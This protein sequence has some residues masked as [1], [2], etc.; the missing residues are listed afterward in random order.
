MGH[1]NLQVRPKPRMPPY[2]IVMNKSPPSTP[3][4]SSLL[5]FSYEHIYDELTYRN[6]YHNSQSPSLDPTFRS[7]GSHTPNATDRDGATPLLP[8]SALSPKELQGRLEDDYVVENPR[9]KIEMDPFS[10]TEITIMVLSF[11]FV[12]ILIMTAITMTLG[13]LR[14]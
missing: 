14:F 3:S 6:D 2:K 9:N 13:I 11:L 5:A 7:S 10:P 4:E 1:G 8:R 12:G